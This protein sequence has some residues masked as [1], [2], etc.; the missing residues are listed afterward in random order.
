MSSVDVRRLGN[1]S[2]SQ[3]TGR[4]V[5]GALIASTRVGGQDELSSPVQKP[6]V[7]CVCVCVCV[8]ERERERERETLETQSMRHILVGSKT[9]SFMYSS[10]GL[11]VVHCMPMVVTN[12]L[13][14]TFP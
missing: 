4:K 10:E 3:W 13:P 8:C 9:I 12:F 5:P 14:P 2:T 6:E 1:P 7:W 11:L